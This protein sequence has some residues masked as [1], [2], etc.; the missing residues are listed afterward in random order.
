M[1]KRPLADVLSLTIATV[2]EFTG[3]FFWVQYVDGGMV[4][5]G[6]SIMVIGLLAE[7]IAVYIA[8]RA[9][10]GDNPPHPYIALNLIGAGLGESLAWL[11]WLYLADSV[12][13]IL[14]AVVLTV[15]ILIEHSIQLGYFRRGRRFAYITDPRTI[16]FSALEGVA[17]FFWLFY[18]RDHALI[19]AAILFIGL[20]VEH[21]IQGSLLGL[22][23]REDRKLPA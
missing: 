15:I 5:L 4:A 3:L 16:V 11:L 18:V 8:I 23:D 6:I 2:A 13:P 22:E 20:T 19:G 1:F 21:I 7:R 9:V 12:D 17:A 10:Y 14:A